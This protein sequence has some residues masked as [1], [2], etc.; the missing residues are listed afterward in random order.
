[1][2]LS[3][4]EWPPQDNIT[5]PTPRTKNPHQKSQQAPQ[6]K[7]RA[8]RRVR[9]Q[10]NEDPDERK[11]KDY[12][13]PSPE[14]TDNIYETS[15]D[16]SLGDFPPK[17]TS[18]SNEKKEVVKTQDVTITEED[19]DVDVNTYKLLGNGSDENDH[20]EFE[21]QQYLK[22]Y[23]NWGLPGNPYNQNRPNNNSGKAAANANVNE[24][25]LKKLNYMIHLLEEQKDEKTNNV[26]EEVILYVFLGIF[27]IF[28]VD[29]FSKSGK[30]VR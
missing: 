13:A 11:Y 15:L 5:T 9:P 14:L 4:A 7:R 3:F 25:L 20:A 24:D 28:I 6:F 2:S 22:S 12:S 8:T 23:K 29:S 17:P 1:M 26:T 30:Y 21:Y 19:E 10:Q 18:V 27:I 16:G